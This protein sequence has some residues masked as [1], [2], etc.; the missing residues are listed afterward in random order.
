MWDIGLTSPKGIIKFRPRENATKPNPKG[1]WTAKRTNKGSSR[2]SQK[3]HRRDKGCLS[4]KRAAAGE[5]E[6]VVWL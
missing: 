6:P 5:T 1:K 3:T 2:I 4:P